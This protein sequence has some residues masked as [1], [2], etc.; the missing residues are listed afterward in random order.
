MTLDQ[1]KAEAVKANEID[2]QWDMLTDKNNEKDFVHALELAV[3]SIP[4]IEYIYT[5]V[6]GGSSNLPL[7]EQE[8]IL[9][10]CADELFAAYQLQEILH[11]YKMVSEITV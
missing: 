4:G 10:K 11:R 8:E 3:T 9:D 6:S 2:I 1:L 7:N 5:M